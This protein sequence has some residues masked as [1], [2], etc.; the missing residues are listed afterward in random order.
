MSLILHTKFHQNRSSGSW[1]EDFFKVFNNIWAWQ[2]SSSCDQHY[3]DE[4][5]LT[6]TYKLNIQNVVENGSKVSKKSK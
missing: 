1:K 4:F 5:S 2:P 3:V 6:C